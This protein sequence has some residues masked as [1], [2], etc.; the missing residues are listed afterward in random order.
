[1]AHASQ[2]VPYFTKKTLQKL[3]AL[4]LLLGHA[5]GNARQHKH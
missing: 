1:M 2:R 3:T 4:Y 5:L